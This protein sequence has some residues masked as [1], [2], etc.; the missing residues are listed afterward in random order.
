[1]AALAP[2]NSNAAPTH[3]VAGCPPAVAAAISSALSHYPESGLVEDPSGRRF[4][5]DD[6]EISP[7]L[8][9]EGKFGRVFRA[10]EK[11]SR[12]IVVIKSIDKQAILEEDVKGQLQREVEVH[13]RLRRGQAAVL[14]AFIQALIYCPTS[15]DTR[16][17]SVYLHI[18]TT[19]TGVGGWRVLQPSA[20]HHIC[21]FPVYLVLECVSGGNVYQRLQ[22]APG[23]RFSEPLAASLVQ[24]L[25]L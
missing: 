13:C 24:Q 16:T 5:L 9:G 15:T 4:T 8:L 10:R 11:A 6:F 14:G 22:E 25:C 18:L 7:S 20:E 3:P 21:L 1:M 2:S 17:S 19:R 12:R 23:K